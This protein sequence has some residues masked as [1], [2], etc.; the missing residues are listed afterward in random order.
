MELD[1]VWQAS[2]A[3][4]EH[5]ASKLRMRG[6]EARGTLDELQLKAHLAKADAR[7]GLEEAR[8]K[9]TEIERR[10]HFFKAASQTELHELLGR[11]GGV[12]S[13][14]RSSLGKDTDEAKSGPQD[15]ASQSA[16]H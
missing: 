16:K 3:K 5:E 6:I 4:F 10:L 14:L 15:D 7:D 2:R 1:D 13:S 12:F 9:V 8:N 11:V